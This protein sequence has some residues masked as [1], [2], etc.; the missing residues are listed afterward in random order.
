MPCFHLIPRAFL[1]LV[2]PECSL[3]SKPWLSYLRAHR[4][5]TFAA[6]CAEGEKGHLIK[7]PPAS[8][9]FHLSSLDPPCI[10]GHVFSHLWTTNL[11]ARQCSLSVMWRRTYLLLALVRL[12]FALSP[13]YLHPD[14]NFQGPE[15]IAGTFARTPCLCR[16]IICPALWSSSG[17][18]RACTKLDRVSL[19][20][21]SCA[22]MRIASQHS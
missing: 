19:A 1:S 5:F 10:A 6:L 8:S 12:W 2:S 4:D 11:C 22:R 14:E 13:S 20:L 9:F 7:P 16:A 21:G 17:V 15:V 3:P 18:L